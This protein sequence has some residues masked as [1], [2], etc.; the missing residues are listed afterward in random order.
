MTVS[1]PPD[2]GMTVSPPPGRRY[3]RLRDILALD[4]ETEYERIWRLITAYEFPW[5]FWQSASLAF[6]RTFGIPSIAT[7][8]HRTGEICHHTQK[9]ADDTLL[10][11]FEIGR[12]GLET[13]E[14]RAYLRRMNRMHHRYTIG[15]GDHLYII[16][17]Y[18]TVPAQ[19]ID[20]FGWRPLTGHEKDALAAY[21]RRLAHVMG[22]TDVPGTF[23]AFGAFAR[24]YE[25]EHFAATQSSRRLAAASVDIAAD[26]L[27]APLRRPLRS[28][29]RR[30]S[31]A[32][33]DERILDATGLPR[34]TP[35]DRRLA[36][37]VLRLRGRLLR[38]LPPRPDHRPHR[39]ALATYPQGH[40]LADVGP[41]W[42]RSPRNGST[43][44][45]D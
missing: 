25:E 36:T 28:T 29:V 2:R 32:L 20:R 27:P 41:D 33:L 10:I 43:R 31:L 23:G 45:M 9:R 19:W 34:P 13:D 12:L 38:R 18:V 11:L 7:L 17:L 30:L 1:P 14:G 24:S 42:M 21:G 5:D 3:D 40:R 16:A 6:F 39:L 15:N 4:P 44:P 22:V 35:R 8:L 26:M 37:A